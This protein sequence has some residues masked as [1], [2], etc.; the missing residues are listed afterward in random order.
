MIG[1]LRVKVYCVYVLQEIELTQKKLECER[2][3]SDIKSEKTRSKT[4]VSTIKPVLRGH[5][6]KGSPVLSS[7]FLCILG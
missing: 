2:L 1:A 4:L 3:S 7:Q 5:C 6:I